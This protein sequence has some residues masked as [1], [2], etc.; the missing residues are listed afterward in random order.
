MSAS[1]LTLLLLFLGSLSAFFYILR[2]TSSPQKHPKHEKK[3]PPGPRP[4]PIIGNLHLFGKLPHQTLHHLAKKY[5]PIM[6]VRLG[7]VPTIVVSSPQAA[8]LFLKT[9]DAVFA[10]RPQLQ[11]VEYMA[12]GNK[13][14]AFSA[15]GS[16]WRGVRKW[17]ILHIL[18]PSKVESFA[19]IRRAEVESLVKS[20]R[21]ASAADE[22]VDLTKKADEVVE[23]IMFKIILGRNKDDRFDFKPLVREALRLIGTFN[24]SDF[25]PYLAPLD[26]QGLKRKV[27][28]VGE[29][30]DKLL[31]III[32]EHEQEAKHQKPHR[33]FVDEVLTL[34]NQ[35]LNPN[36]HEEQPYIVDRSNI[37]AII[38]DM[39]V[40]S[41][42]TSSTTIEW[43]F[44]ELLKNPQIMQH[45]QNEIESVV[46]RNRMVEESDLSRLT[47]LDMVL[48][49]TYRLHPI[50][51]LLLPHESR[52]DITIDEY[53][54]PKKSRVLIN[55]W[56]MARDPNVW[57]NAEEFCPE[58]FRTSDINFRGQHFQLL[59]F[60]T[61]RRGCPGMQLGLATVRLVIAQLVHC[62]DWEL[63]KGMLPTELD[64]D[65]KFGLT[66]PRANHLF[67]KP[68]YRLLDKSM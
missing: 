57:D 65:E 42:D 53:Y 26:L 34:V 23:D 52:E 30:I 10:N 58:R 43:V 55:V 47:Y 46:G 12:K 36:D 45:L 20:T 14:M 64:M 3:L 6:L 68:T 21:K 5:G 13:G 11:A 25:L 22:L 1:A 8:E 37:K 27:G 31:K 32:E 18:S 62:F 17:C 33:D 9:H 4:L 50:T 48:R 38:I 66:T 35:P 15:Y 19:P 44:S 56:S 28:R 2:A 49:E 39:I 60:G 7:C 41:F 29:S 40:A 63:P 16:Y 51:P 24:L 61:G 67:A 59:P 54:I